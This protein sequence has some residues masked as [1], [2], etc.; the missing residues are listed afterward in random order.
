MQILNKTK[1][2][3]KDNMLLRLILFIARQQLI[4]KKGNLFKTK[5][6]MLKSFYSFSIRIIDPLAK[7]IKHLVS[8]LF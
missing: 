8:C 3:N 2:G 5:N 7:L 6:A 1:T 4:I